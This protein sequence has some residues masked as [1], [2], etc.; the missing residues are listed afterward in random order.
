MSMGT[1]AER[2]APL[3]VALLPPYLLLRYRHHRLSSSS[4]RSKY[5]LYAGRR[6]AS[7]RWEREPIVFSQYGS[8]EEEQIEVQARAGV[9]CGLV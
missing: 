9:L 5:G 8:D 6:E 7:Q 3:S 2:Y 4:G 1:H